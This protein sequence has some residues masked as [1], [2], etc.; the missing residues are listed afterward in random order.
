MSK[1][2]DDLSSLTA[3]QQAAIQEF[4]YKNY[5]S[6]PTDDNTQ[7][8]IPFIAMNDGQTPAQI[9]ASSQGIYKDIQ[10]SPFLRK[11]GTF[12]ADGSIED[13]DITALVYYGTLQQ[14]KVAPTLENIDVKLYVRE[15]G[16]KKVP[17]SKEEGLTA[18]TYFWREVH[19]GFHVYNNDTIYGYD[20]VVLQESYASTAGVYNLHMNIE[21]GLGACKIGG[22][23]SPVTLAGVQYKVVIT[24]KSL[25]NREYSLLDSMPL[26]QNLEAE[27]STLAPSVNAIKEY[28]SKA[29]ETAKLVTEG[30]F[31]TTDGKNNYAFTVDNNGIFAEDIKLKDI[32]SL[33]NHVKAARAD[34]DKHLTLSYNPALDSQYPHG[35]NNAGINGNINAHSLAGL[36]ISNAYNTVSENITAKD[37]YIP[38]VNSNQVINLGR[39]VKNHLGIEAT[40]PTFDETFTISDNSDGTTTFW[41]E[42]TVNAP[43]SNDFKYLLAIPSTK[44]IARIRKGEED[45]SAAIELS[46]GSTGK[47]NVNVTLN[48]LIANS[49]K[50]GDKELDKTSLMHLTGSSSLAYKEPISE[51][52]PIKFK[53]NV[54]TPNVDF[55]QDG[56]PVSE[57]DLKGKNTEGLQVKAKTVTDSGD[58]EVDSTFSGL[59]KLGSAL[60]ALH[61]LPLST[62]EYKGDQNS[63]KEQLGIFVERVNQLRNGLLKGDIKPEHKRNSRIQSS[64]EAILD[65]DEG[66]GI[67]DAAE[68]KDDEAARYYGE[69]KSR[70]DNNS[71]EYTDEEVKSIAHYLDLMTSKQELSHD[72]KNTV[73]ILL[74]AAQET[75]DRLLDVETAVYGWDASSI[76]GKDK[77]ITSAI[78]EDLQAA[79]NNSPLFLGLNRLMRALCLEVYDTT[80]LE[81]IDAETVSVA[82]DS[83]TLKE[84]VTIKSRMDQIDI[85]IS[86][87]QSEV[88]AQTSALAHMYIEN[89]END[90]CAHTYTDMYHIVEDK[91][92]SATDPETIA[93]EETEVLT[94]EEK[95]TT[96]PDIAENED[97]ANSLLAKVNDS[98]GTGIDTTHDKGRTWYCLPSAAD[99]KEKSNVGFANISSNAGKHTPEKGECGIVRVPDCEDVDYNVVTEDGKT[100]KQTWKKLKLAKTVRKDSDGKEVE[101]FEPVFSSKVVAWDSAKLERMN[102][103]LSE[104][105]KTI[106]GVDDVVANLPNRTEV[107]RRNITN[108]IDDLYPNRKFDVEP[109][110][111][112]ATAVTSD[113]RAPFKGSKVQNPAGNVAGLV[114]DEG[115]LTGSHTS[116]IK[117]FDDALFNFTVDCNLINGDY[118]KYEE[119]ASSAEGNK[120]NSGFDWKSNFKSIA[121]NKVTLST[122]KLVTDEA[123]KGSYSNA[124]SRL[125]YIENLIGVKDCYDAKLF[126]KS[127]LTITGLTSLGTKDL[128]SSIAESKEEDELSNLRELYKG[129]IGFNDLSVI[130]NAEKSESGK[131]SDDLSSATTT[132]AYLSRKLK[133]IQERVTT[134]EA[135][136]DEIS[137]G[138]QSIHP[139]EVTATRYEASDSTQVFKDLGEII[140]DKTAETLVYDL[141]LSESLDVK[142]K[143]E[144]EE[145]ERVIDWLE[146][147]RKVWSI[148]TGSKD[149]TKSAYTSNGPDDDFS[150]NVTG[151]YTLKGIYVREHPAYPFETG[152]EK[153]NSWTIHVLYCNGAPVKHTNELKSNR[154]YLKSKSTALVG[155]FI[156][157]NS[158]SVLLVDDTKSDSNSNVAASYQNQ[159]EANIY[160]TIQKLFNSLFDYD[161]NGKKEPADDSLYYKAML[162][163]H[164]VGTVYFTADSTFDPE[165]QFGGNWVAL[166]NDKVIQTGPKEG[167][168][169]NFNG[170]T[171]DAMIF[172]ETE[173]TATGTLDTTVTIKAS[174]IVDQ[175]SINASSFKVNAPETATG[176]LTFEVSDTNITCTGA[177]HKLAKVKDGA[178]NVSIGLKYDGQNNICRDL[179]DD[180]SIVSNLEPIE[181]DNLLKNC[182]VKA[183]DVNLSLKDLKPKELTVTPVESFS[184]IQ[185]TG[186]NGITIGESEKSVTTSI[187]TLQLKGWLRIS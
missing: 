143:V 25:W 142:V 117:Y 102:N 100:Y 174:D 5:S 83:D 132:N 75:Q 87:I 12:K 91:R 119:N 39:T 4:L 153:D 136:A 14:A 133:T 70:V 154:I 65:F 150:D 34:I 96:A 108:L 33:Y 149:V 27:T 85:L 59:T 44:L 67:D 80:D 167:L 171:E 187:Q 30:L 17:S 122:E 3:E 37:A 139:N 97:A 104:V 68:I 42:D 57:V 137:K 2:F 162:R 166:P 35:L 10:R 186:A 99:L 125:D 130:E 112:L 41:V 176:K 73:G 135:Y 82:T 66:L 56:N 98:H 32:E 58:I 146:H 86:R 74:K 15:P 173:A 181:V 76:P 168:R 182:N 45:N 144:G 115:K 49:V 127:I 183:T 16:L 22:H 62:Y 72:I 160:K 89:V 50:I 26:I 121:D 138:M 95:L 163:A 158:D 46:A 118:A 51:S 172:N 40:S 147:N 161:P 11:T 36:T 131:L 155:N 54:L 7:F 69:F 140:H 165:I 43:G 170:I 180:S 129:E 145:A 8:V 178:E 23:R 77:T 113:I 53:T 90:E 94:K 185:R 79:L 116:I 114:T 101:T 48:K 141:D 9:K 152:L 21:N 88:A 20:W 19:P 148:V 134:L 93:S 71:Y 151:H 156:N 78:D 179:V 55:D 175:L 52:L 61:E 13:I 109:K 111:E 38:Y 105:T 120:N 126:D 29:V 169:Y 107:L 157:G 92:Q 63:Y 103:K 123:D 184:I 47:G 24:A 18:D 177:T 128:N 60:Q 1:E 164:P 110:V 6:R 159:T 28:Y 64:N 81:T 84:K 124:Y 106:Y 31:V